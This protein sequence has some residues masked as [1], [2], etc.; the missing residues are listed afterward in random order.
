M[1]IAVSRGSS[2]A[3]FHPPNFMN[4]P[5]NSPARN[6]SAIFDAPL[7]FVAAAGLLAML[8]CYLWGFPAGADLD[9]HFRFALPLYEEIGRGNFF[10]G[11][12][13]ES[14]HG[15]GDPRFRF[16]PPLLYYALCLSR[17]V[18]GDWYS[19]ALAVYTL[20]SIAGPLGVYLWTRRSLSRRTAALAGALFAF[21]P[22]H[23]AQ[24]FQAS[25]L[26][27]YAATALL[28]YAFLF[29]EKL[30]T[31]TDERLSAKLSAVAGL[32]AFYALIVTTHLP[33]T[34]IGSFSLGL[35]ALLS[36]DWK[37]DKRALFF[38]A[39][40]VALGLVASAWFWL[41][42]MPELGWIQAGEK[43]SSEYYDYRHNFVFSPFAPANL[44]TFYGSLVA[45][46]TIG[47]LLPSVIIWRRLFA[48]NGEPEAG[49]AA[50]PIVRRR[51]IAALCVALGALLMT[52]D[53][54]RPV[55]AVVPKLKDVQFP[56]RWL[57]VASVMICPLVALSLTHWR[58]RMRERNFR[59]VH[60]VVLL[61]FAG[62][63]GW[64][65]ADLMLDA[66]FF[67]RA[68]FNQ[69]VEQA[70]GGRSF[71]DWLPRGAA[72]L[73]DVFPLDGQI[74]AN[75]R[76]VS[77]LEWQ[78]HRRVFTVA[79]GQRAAARLR[80]YDYPLWRAFRLAEGRRIELETSPAPDGT[81]LV[82]LPAGSATIE[83]VFTEPPRVQFSRYL[84]ALGWTIVFALLII[85][86]IKSKVS[87][88]A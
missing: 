73:K 31:A 16:Y 47:F 86:F 87:S 1:R 23:A 58:Q 3:E 54:S 43:V 52:T 46:L 59:A 17:F 51:L 36:T 12:L 84:S 60:F 27:E 30:T 11:W 9:N 35:Y 28:P 79:E 5:P 34:V 55:W 56:Y 39:A 50:A 21:V 76:A 74:D 65:I 19:A 24:F 53:L 57:A 49:A 68:R 14:N 69:R 82:A 61:L 7:L 44:N 32:G 8:P 62:A 45:A 80:A 83:V 67:S 48:E 42:M 29:V 88:E 66:E 70:R 71:N 26:A 25:L 78:T 18:T 63:L 10:P 38:C 64:T 2:T 20:L 13:A 15:F 81:L 37:A 33:S 85:G 4:A 6:A 77:I 41:R 40:G 72:E 22:Y 75:G